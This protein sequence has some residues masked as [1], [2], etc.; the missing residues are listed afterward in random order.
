MQIIG[1]RAKNRQRGAILAMVGVAMLVLA[2]S[3]VIGVDVAHLALSAHEAQVAADAGATSGGR[4][5]VEGDAVQTAVD[6]IAGDNT[7]DG[8][9][10]VP[11]DLSV[12]LGTFDFT[13]RSYAAGGAAPNAVHVTVTRAVTNFWAGVFGD[14]T[15]TVSR[16]AI[17]AVGTVGSG[18][19]DLPLV[20]SDCFFPPDCTTADCLPTLQG[21]PSTT[22]DDAW[23]GFFGNS[24]NAG[25]RDF[26][27]SACGGSGEDIPTV[28]VTD[29]I[30]L[31]NGQVQPAIN[32][33]ECMVCDLGQRQF[34]VPVIANC[35]EN[36]VAASDPSNSSGNGTVV[37][38]ATITIDSFNYDDGGTYDCNAPDGTVPKT[39]N[40][41][42]VIRTDA[43]GP[44]GAPCTGC[45][46]FSV[47]LVS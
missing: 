31:S 29:E 46:T 41:R 12:D 4:A 34:T 44:P 28:N 25:L 11:A 47:G 6:A 10:V 22:D 15:S 21:Y 9:A 5:L 17:A 8:T 3:A 39:M 26:F 32:A 18:K 40:L 14:P 24:S 13:T 30:S 33:I 7:I 16:E 37:G 19:A 45:G 23:T 42:S 43:V 35:N 27:P 38:F 2:G 36:F 1:R 20:L